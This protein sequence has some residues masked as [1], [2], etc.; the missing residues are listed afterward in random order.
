[1][2]FYVKYISL[3]GGDEHGVGAPC[4]F[5]LTSA[6]E[7]RRAGRLAIVASNSFPAIACSLAVA[8]ISVDHGG[9]ARPLP[10]PR[11]MAR[12]RP[13][14]GVRVPN[15]RRAKDHTLSRPGARRR[16]RAARCADRAD[17]VRDTDA[18]HAPV[19]PFR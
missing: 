6:T 9:M 5:P 19:D 1:N 3:R 4:R 15:R 11:E 13:S 10:F 12:S 16:W 7:V 18:E 8:A 17:S 14:I 2:S